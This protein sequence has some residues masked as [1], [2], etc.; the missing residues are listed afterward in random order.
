MSYPLAD[1]AVRERAATANNENIVVTAGAGTGKTTLLIDRLTHLLFRPNQ[2]LSLGQIVALTFTNKAANEMKI[3]LRQR[4]QVMQELARGGLSDKDSQGHE[5]KVI[6]DLQAF[7]GLTDQHIAYVAEQTFY[8][9]ERAHIETIHSF[10]GYVLRLFPVEAGVDPS[11]QEDDGTQFAAHF[12]G[13]WNRWLAHELQKDGPNR[14]YWRAILR[15]VRLED[16]EQF[17]RVLMNE[18]VPFASLAA[19]QDDGLLP[20]PIRN[21]IFGLLE[22]ARELRK[23]YD[24]EQKL[25]LLLDEAID[26]LNAVIHGV[27][28]EP[29]IR[30]S[31]RNPKIPPKPKS[32]SDEDYLHARSIVKVAQAS[33]TLA[34]KALRDFLRTLLPFLGECQRTYLNAG[35]VSFD[36]LIVKARD[37]LRDTPRVRCDIKQQFQAILVDE[38]QDTDP[39]QYELILYVAEKSNHEARAWPQIQL[40]PGK[41]FIVGDPKQSIYAFRRADIEAYDFVIHDL[42]LK[43]SVQ[44]EPLS[45]RSNFRSHAGVLGPVNALC[46]QWFPHEAIK[47]VQP[48]YE[49]LV[50]VERDSKTFKT[51][52]FRSESC[53]LPKM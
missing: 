45:L 11:F 46:Q 51:K 31:L 7:Y 34:P 24:K 37:L 16:L 32:W 41:L 36:G 53:N 39:V 25:E 48:Q 33:R 19:I 9:L 4:L 20:Q 14:E 6:R 15:L 38:F 42:V 29:E 30:E 13:E 49:T 23:V 27:Y 17:A 22:T 47:G 5:A 10:A 8:D 50:P 1:Q 18:L 12:H 3:R 44:K 43:Q 2:R 28:F 21:W 26:Q 52:A 40:E 35:W